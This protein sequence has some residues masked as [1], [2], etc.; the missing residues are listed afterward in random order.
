[1]QHNR[2]QQSQKFGA[3]S[4]NNLSI[5]ETVEENVDI[6]NVPKLAWP[7]VQ[8]SSPRKTDDDNGIA[9]ANLR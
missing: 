4:I 7:I 9:L 2:S 3:A 5:T 8:G 6:N 1:M